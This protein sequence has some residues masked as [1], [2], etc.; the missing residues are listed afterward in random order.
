MRLRIFIICSLSLKMA[1]VLEV[2]MVECHIKDKILKYI[3]IQALLR[4]RTG[5]TYVRERLAL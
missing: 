4:E 2:K 5:M 3:D 1:K